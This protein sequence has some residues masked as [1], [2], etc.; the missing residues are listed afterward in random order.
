[1][2]TSWKRWDRE[3][4][5]FLIIV[6]VILG[7]FIALFCAD[8]RAMTGRADIAE[9]ALGKVKKDVTEGVELS[10]RGIHVERLAGNI[11]KEKFW[12]GEFSAYRQLRDCLNCLPK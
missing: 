1:M 4:G 2:Q 6:L 11:V 12:K 3:Q 7:I 5:L 9:W 8:V 10:E